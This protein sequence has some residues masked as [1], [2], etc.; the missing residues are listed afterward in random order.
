VTNHFA[1]LVDE[2]DHHKLQ[3]LDKWKKL[4]IDDDYM[5]HHDFYPPKH[6]FDAKVRKMLSNWQAHKPQMFAMVGT[7]NRKGLSKFKNK[8]ISKHMNVEPTWT[9][10]HTFACN[11][12]NNQII[13]EMNLEATWTTIYTF[14]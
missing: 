6:P 9:I 10:T 1:T 12:T 13:D 5:L 7:W 2:L 11:L 3:T 8:Q 4:S 14:R